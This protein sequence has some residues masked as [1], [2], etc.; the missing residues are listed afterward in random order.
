MIKLKPLSRFSQ[1]L[2]GKSYG[3]WVH[4]E[5]VNF[6]TLR[7]FFLFVPFGLYFEGG[8]AVVKPYCLNIVSLTFFFFSKNFSFRDF[9]VLKLVNLYP[10][11]FQ[12]DF[13]FSFFFSK[14]IFDVT[15]V[16]IT[17]F[18]VVK[19]FIFHFDLS[20]KFCFPFVSLKVTF[21]FFW[22]MTI[23]SLFGFS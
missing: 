16:S 20:N 1:M 22:L 8:L 18:F 14:Q 21:Y 5:N 2:W 9:F 19:I 12:K 15:L 10:F 7:I 23:V 13:L 17:V 11:V 6:V 4:F 3:F